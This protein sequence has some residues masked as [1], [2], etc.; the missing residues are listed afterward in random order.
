MSGMKSDK[1][2]GNDG[3][4]VNVVIKVKREAKIQ[5]AVVVVVVVVE[6]VGSRTILFAGARARQVPV[7]S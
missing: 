7:T 4:S 1:M 6:V 5:D 3:F 2:S